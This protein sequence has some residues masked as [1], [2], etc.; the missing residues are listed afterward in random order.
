MKCTVQ[1]AGGEEN[2][3]GGAI[4]LALPQKQ[5]E[6]PPPQRVFQVT[7]MLVRPLEQVLGSVPSFPFP[8]HPTLQRHPADTETT[9][10]SDLSLAALAASGKAPDGSRFHRVLRCPSGAKNPDGGDLFIPA[11]M[12]SR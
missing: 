10:P 7:K 2:T 12:Q 5:E 4:T 11:E 8:E 6:C 1:S 9:A 3:Q